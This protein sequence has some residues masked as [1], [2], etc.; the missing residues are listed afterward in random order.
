VLL[1]FTPLAWLAV[2]GP[3]SLVWLWAAF[4]VGFIGARAVVLLLRARTDRWLVT[5]SR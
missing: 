5:G 2:S 1:V 4:G 3:A